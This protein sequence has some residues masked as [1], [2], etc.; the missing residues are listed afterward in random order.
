V[1]REAQTAP[2]LTAQHSTR[3]GRTHVTLQHDPPPLELTVVH[4]CFVPELFPRIRAARIGIAIE[5][6]R[7]SDVR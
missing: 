2:C 5:Y 4:P 3:H 6:P 7:V 1:E